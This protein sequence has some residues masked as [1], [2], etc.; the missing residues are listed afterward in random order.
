M[1]TI[2]DEIAT[3]QLHSRLSR[4]NFLATVRGHSSRTISG[5]T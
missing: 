2:H 1:D 3:V 5:Y 4:R